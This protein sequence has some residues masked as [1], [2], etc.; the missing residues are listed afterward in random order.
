MVYLCKK[1]VFG[2]QRSRRRGRIKMLIFLL[3]L[4]PHNCH[5]TSISDRLTNFKSFIWK[6]GFFGKNGFLGS[7]VKMEGSHAKI[8][9]IFEISTI[10]LPYV[11]ILDAI[12]I[13]LFSPKNLQCVLNKMIRPTCYVGTAQLYIIV[14]FSIKVD[15]L[16]LW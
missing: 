5:I 2:G 6:M 1:W 9:S 14:D 4:S 7:K 10:D 15:L 16:S 12:P 3:N 8:D 13:Y 11:D